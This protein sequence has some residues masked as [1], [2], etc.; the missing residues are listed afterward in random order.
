MITFINNFYFRAFLFLLACLL[1]GISSLNI[2]ISEKLPEAQ[3]IR[4]IELQVPLKIFTADNKL[5]GEFGEKR[6]SALKF[7]DIP[8]YFVKA[9]L[10]AE[11]DDFFNHSGVSYSGLIRSVFRILVSGEVRGG[12]S[13]I[14]MQVAGNY[15]TGR[16]INLFRK[17]K[18]IF[19]AYRLERIYS[20]E[21]IFEFYVNRIF[22]GNRAYGIA[23]A[24][25]VYYG[26]S[27]ENLNLAQWA[28]IAGL[29]VAPSY[30][31]PLNNPRR[32]LIRRNWI[33]TRMLDLGFIYKEQYDLAIKAPISATYHGLVSEVNAP[34]L[35]ETIRRFMINEYGLDAYKEGLKV[36]TT[37][38]SKLQNLAVAALKK[39]LETYDK[40]HGFRVPENYTDV[41]PENFFV[42][43][44]KYRFNLI[45]ESKSLPLGISEVPEDEPLENI[46]TL[47]NNITTT[48]NKFPA[49]VLSVQDDLV[50]VSGDRTV[51]KVSWSSDL[52]WAR[53]Y[54][55]EDQRGPKPKSFSELLK[56]GDL[57]WLEKDKI[58][59]SISLTQI[60][61]V[62][63]SIVAMDPKNGRVKALVG[64]YDFFLSKYNRATQSSPLLGSNYKPFLYASALD[65]GLTASTLINDAP[66]VFEDK[67]LEDKWRPR[68]ASGRFYGPTRLREA[69]L[70][71]INLVSIRLLREVGIERVR[72]YSENFGFK[73]D[74]LNSDLSLALGTASLS[75]I[76]NASA[77][78]VF[79]NGG[80]AVEP[81]FIT[82]IVDRTGE[83]IF[84]KE[85]PETKQVIDAR[86]AFII[87]DIL[88]EA[89]KRGTAK[90]ISEL[91][92]GD[93]AGKTGTTNEAESTWFTGFNEFLVTTVW[94]GF[95]QPKSLGNREFGS[96]TALPIWLD[97]MRPNI[98]FLPRNKNLPPNG[99]VSIKVDKKTGLKLESNSGNSIFEYYLEEYLP[100]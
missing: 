48:D 16:D 19:L 44:L 50:T 33:L 52:S 22:L 60:P 97:F 12:G 10:A 5:I 29:P 95:D 70:Q 55:S 66:I 20:K 94:V 96:S 34:Y 61:E 93:L 24:S 58:K 28:M 65:A 7:N 6:R 86:I 67:A 99:I 84:Q 85:E 42:E 15:L 31:N 80:K 25:E 26:T 4:E 39:G 89:A 46:Y 87:Q 79:A 32:A 36:Y 27:I 18:D 57:V 1:A 62:Q 49:L 56:E 40:R 17:I 59:S 43:D 98:D 81:Y 72:K 77:Y 8:P 53:P 35:A 75:P 64:G 71:S 30:R 45:A 91:G 73:L 82:T 69:L 2:Y 92:R 9:V 88:Q 38:D 51:L 13:T 21:E 76:K 47:L 3:E 11:D 68:N 90:K 41:F 14:T 83:V 100:E 54:I 23:S 74:E 63:G 37:I 78:S